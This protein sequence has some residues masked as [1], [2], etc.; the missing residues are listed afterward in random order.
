MHTQLT[1][2]AA[3]FDTADRQRRAL[4]VRQARGLP[5]SPARSLIVRLIPKRIA[6]D[7]GRAAGPPAAPVTPAGELVR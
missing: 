4:S 5:A 7:P 6:T 3:K 1:Y 2:I